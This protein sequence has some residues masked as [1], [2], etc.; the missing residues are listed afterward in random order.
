MTFDSI[1][2]QLPTFSSLTLLSMPMTHRHAEIWNP[3]V[4]RDLLLSPPYKKLSRLNADEKVGL[5]VCCLADLS[6]NAHLEILFYDQIKL[7]KRVIS[8]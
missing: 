8:K 1:S 4:L 6:R 3:S 2:P 7:F 5:T